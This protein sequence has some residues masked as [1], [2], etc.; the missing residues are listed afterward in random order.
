MKNPVSFLTFASISLTV[1]LLSQYLTASGAR[2]LFSE[3]FHTNASAVC[4]AFFGTARIAQLFFGIYTA[5]MCGKNRFVNLYFFGFSQA[6]YIIVHVLL[7]ENRIRFLAAIFLLI[8]LF[9][10]AALLKASGDDKKRF[11]FLLPQM[12]VYLFMLLMCFRGK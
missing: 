7:F 6:V 1:C 8:L 9:V 10:S 3:V 12:A 2:E 11:P 5:K 4:A